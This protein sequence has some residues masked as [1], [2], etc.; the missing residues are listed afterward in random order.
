MEY[1]VTTMTER[2]DAEAVG[3]ARERPVDGSETVEAYE[4]DGAVVLYD[5]EN[6]LAWIETSRAV[7]ITECV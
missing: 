3:S 4:E 2:V 5:A 1:H 7:R 6:P